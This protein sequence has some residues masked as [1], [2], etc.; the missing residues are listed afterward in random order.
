MPALT[1]ADLAAIRTR[2]IERQLTWYVYQPETIWT[3][4][5]GGAP[6]RGDRSLTVA[7]V[8]AHQ[9][10]E[11]GQML[12]T[13]K[14]IPYAVERRVLDQALAGLGTAPALSVTALGCLL[15]F[16]NPEP[17]YRLMSQV[18]TP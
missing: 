6:S 11:G 18:V 8:N 9:V 14:V 15:L 2:P 13:V 5:V 3:G 17:V 7:T 10:V 1:G 16:L 4:T 12:A